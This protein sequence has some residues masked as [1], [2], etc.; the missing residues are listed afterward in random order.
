MSSTSARACHLPF[1][2]GGAS[3]IGRMRSH[4]PSSRFL[5]V[6]KRK[7]TLKRAESP[8]PVYVG[9]GAHQYANYYFWD[10]T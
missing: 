5:E 9:G 2:L 8:L 4:S 6:L 7:K 1:V 10:W 3:R